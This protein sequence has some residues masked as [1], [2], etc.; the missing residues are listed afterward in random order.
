MPRFVLLGIFL[1][2]FIGFSQPDTEVFLFDLDRSGDGFKLRNYKNVSENKGY[3]NQ[4]SFLDNNTLLFSSTR[5]G[6]TDIAKFN[7]Q[8][9]VK[10][11][12][13]FTPGSE[14]SPIKIPG[15][16]AVSAIRLDED[17]TQQLFKYN[18]SNGESKLLISD[19]VVGY[20]IWYS[21]DILIASILEEDG[22]S[23]IAQ[24]FKEDKYYKLQK[25]VGRSLH[26]IPDSN[27]I[28]YISKEDDNLWEI[29]SLDPIS[30]STEGIMGTL[31]EQEDMCWLPDGT[32]L[33]GYE[34]ILYTFRPEKDVDWIEQLRL[35][36]Y[37]ITNISRLAVSPDGSK[38]AVV[39][40]GGLNSKADDQ[41][42]ILKPSLENIAWIAGNWRGE[43]LGGIAE[44]NWSQPNGD[45]MMATFRIIKDDKVMFYEIEIIR[46]V[47]NTLIL[48]LKHFNNDL[49]G[50]E[51][52]DETVDFPLK[53]IFKNK[54]VFEGMTFER[55]DETHM[56]VYVDVENEGTTSTL[57]FEYTR[58]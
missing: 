8:Y 12:L 28:S 17:G 6:Q 57:K 53:N 10:S 3:D 13:N 42:E 52:K 49:T 31:P 21:D 23:L 35:S 45:S 39:G 36:D 50:W 32:I 2:S 4:P 20:Q 48:Q 15:E 27:R 9:G 33:M 55:L 26:K 51:S 38:L 1:I 5:K 56:N 34:D 14:Y 46:E 24:Y 37:N 58:Q 25:K 40:E 18:L 47:N 19:P 16:N 11:W 43:A 7:L 44:E 22:L 41:T 29:K 54:V 30:G